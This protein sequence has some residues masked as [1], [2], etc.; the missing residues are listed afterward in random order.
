MDSL[1][2]ISAASIH[3]F[4]EEMKILKFL[5]PVFHFRA[6]GEQEHK[7]QNFMMWLSCFFLEFET[8][9][10]AGSQ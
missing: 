9:D 8:V 7:R 10:C 2:L 1:E 4:D 3:S 5:F 6:N